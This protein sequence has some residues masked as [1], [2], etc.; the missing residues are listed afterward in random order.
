MPIEM[1]IRKLRLHSELVQDDLSALRSIVTP[2]KYFPQDVV[3]V[4]EGDIS[5]Q[6]CVLMSGFAYRSKVSEHGKRQ[7]LSFHIAGDMPDLQGLLLKKMD[8]DLTTL[9]PAQVGFMSHLALRRVIAARPSLGLALWRET[10]LDS[11]TFRQWIVNLG[12][13]TAA[14]RVAYLIAELHQRLGTMG[15][16]KDEQFSFPVTQSKLAEALGLS[17]VHINRVLQS[18]RAQG[19]LDFRKQVVTLRDIEK[20]VELGGFDD[21]SL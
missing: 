13:R 9:S 6:S 15:L 8:H 21:G 14:G 2:V 18:F 10:L 12:T 20:I 3:I 16:V 11:V 4:R 19:V 1:M 17:I 5:T 7:I